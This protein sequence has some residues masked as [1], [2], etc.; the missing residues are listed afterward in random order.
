[1]VKNLH[2]ISDALIYGIMEAFSIDCKIVT[3]E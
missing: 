2:S 1:M 3:L